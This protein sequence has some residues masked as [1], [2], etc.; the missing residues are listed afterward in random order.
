MRLDEFEQLQSSAMGLT[1]H[2]LADSWVCARASVL[3]MG[4]DASHFTACV[5]YWNTVSGCADAKF[6]LDVVL[7]QVTALKN[8]VK[9][10]LRDSGKGWFNLHERS[11][12]VPV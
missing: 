9:N 4:D 5:L 8:A 6:W 7:D 11:R 2:V 1:H 3:S 10:S 12:C